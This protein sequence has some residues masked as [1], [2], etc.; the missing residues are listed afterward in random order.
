[1]GL[2]GEGRLASER[3]CGPPACR[4]LTVLMLRQV[5]TLHI[6]CEWQ[7]VGAIAVGLGFRSG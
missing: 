4:V 5:L 7:P 6:Y 3:G 2:V 1:M